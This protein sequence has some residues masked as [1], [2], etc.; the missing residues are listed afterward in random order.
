LDQGLIDACDDI[1]DAYTRGTI[2]KIALDPHDGLIR[3]GDPRTQLTWMDALRDGV[4]FTPRHGKPIEINALWINALRAR[5]SMGSIDPLRADELESRATRAEQSIVR[6]MTAGPHGG[7]VDC[8]IPHNAVRSF[9]W[10]RSDECRPNQAFATALPG[11]RLPEHIARDVLTAIEHHLLTPV[12]LRTLSAD[13][14]EYQAHYRG[15]MTDRDRAY[16]NGTVWPWLIGA[17]ADTKLRVRAFDD[18]ARKGVIDGLVSLASV[19]NTDG[20]GS[21]H[22]IYDAEAGGNEKHAPQGCP[23]QAW[24]VAEVLRGLVIA[25]RGRA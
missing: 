9:S 16:H 10:R 17:Y 13:H 14:P 25:S 4:A 20:V 23:A 8:L 5:I 21:I 18:T 11:V 15:S 22:E 24:S 12:G 3:C 19:M 7:L 2:N 6:T 1:L